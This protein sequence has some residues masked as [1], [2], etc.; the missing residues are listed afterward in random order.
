MKKKHFLITDLASLD[1]NYGAQAIA[2]PLMVKIKEKYDAEFTFVFP[3]N[4]YKK[5]LEFARLYKFDLIAEPNSL[6]VLAGSSS[7]HFLLNRVRRLRMRVIG[8]NKILQQED[9]RLSQYWHQIQ[10]SDCII[11]ANGIEFVGHTSI[12]KKISSYLANSCAQVAS[13]KFKKPYFKYTKSYGPITPWWY[14]RLA[15][16]RLKALP[17]IF[18]RQGEGSEINL[19]EIKALN[20]KKPIYAFPDISLIALKTDQKWAKSYLR[21]KLKLNPS[22]KIIGIS[23]SAV[24]A[25]LSSGQGTG[26]E[27]LNLMVKLIEYFRQNNQVLI[28]PHSIG[29]GKNTKHCDLAIGKLIF[30]RL[31]D[32]KNIYLLDDNSLTYTQVR[33]IIGIL[34]FYVTSRFHALSSALAMQIPVVALSWHKKYQDLMS[35]FLDEYLVIDSRQTTTGDAY[36]QVKRFYLN[37]SWFNQTLMNKRQKSFV[38]EIDKSINLIVSYLESKRDTQRSCK[39]N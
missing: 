9:A 25:N 33:S 28:L 36:N 5:N 8:Q 1:H 13:A 24:I 20:L 3:L 22:G 34:D 23:P 26:P 31:K 15:K 18:V 38:R 17:Y 6:A 37:R 10:Q 4:Y 29:D 21:H 11:D 2:L 32:K 39:I 27:H 35:L 19:K 14:K 30:N 7:F 12:S 16:N